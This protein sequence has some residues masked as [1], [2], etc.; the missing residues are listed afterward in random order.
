MLNPFDDMTT[1]QSKPLNIIDTEIGDNIGLKSA[2]SALMPPP[3]D[4]SL[5]LYHR[6]T[7]TQKA[8]PCY[9]L[10]FLLGSP[11]EINFEPS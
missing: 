7:L 9:H 2:V 4:L 8:V 1:E 5:I 11:D 6:H 10:G 3:S